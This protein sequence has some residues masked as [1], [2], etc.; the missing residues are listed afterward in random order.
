[1][2]RYNSLQLNLKTVRYYS[3]LELYLKYWEMLQ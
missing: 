3:T 2:R 1:V